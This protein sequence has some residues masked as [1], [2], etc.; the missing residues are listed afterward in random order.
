MTSRHLRWVAVAAILFLP[1]SLRHTENAVK[2]SALTLETL[3]LATVAF[4]LRE[5]QR[6]FGLATVD[7]RARTITRRFWTWL[8]RPFR[9]PP[10]RILLEANAI[11]SAS[12]TAGL[13][14]AT[15]WRTDPVDASIEQRLEI[16][17]ANVVALDQ[18]QKFSDQRTRA[19]HNNT[20]QALEAESAERRA[21]TVRVD[22]TLRN[23]A[24]GGL[25][26][27][28]FGLVLLFVS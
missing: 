17:W 14:L 23:Y 26:L 11:A 19:W 18:R 12:L 7:D 10:P 21:D 3:G 22:A 13:V 8:S 6:Q 28:G 5:T 25:Q 2:L 24:V 9:K 15:G 4:G 20:N 1:W 27:E 16:L